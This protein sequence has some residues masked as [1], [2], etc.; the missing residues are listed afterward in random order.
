MLKKKVAR[1]YI[2]GT[3][4]TVDVFNGGKRRRQRWSDTGI[5]G[6]PGLH[7]GEHAANSGVLIEENVDHMVPVTNN[8]KSTEESTKYCERATYHRFFLTP[9]HVFTESQ[10]QGETGSQMVVD[11]AVPPVEK[12]SS[13]AAV[14]R[15]LERCVGHC[16]E[17]IV[18]RYAVSRPKHTEKERLNEVREEEHASG[19]LKSERLAGDPRTWLT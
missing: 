15:R 4:D 8:T 10:P 6:F 1:A 13:V 7:C 14:S 3:G 2:R 18:L 12:P 17:S 16:D 19:G 5:Y 9:T 11:L